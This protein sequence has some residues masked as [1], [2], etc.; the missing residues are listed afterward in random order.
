MEGS[1]LR[2]VYIVSLF[3]SPLVIQYVHFIEWITGNFFELHSFT[4]VLFVFISPALM[5]I[6]PRISKEYQKI[7]TNIYH[8]PFIISNIPTKALQML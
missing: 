4:C 5:S 7:I 8:N 2:I 6:C 3:C 1:V